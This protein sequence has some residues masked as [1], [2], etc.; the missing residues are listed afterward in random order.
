TILPPTV[1]SATCGRIGTAGGEV[2]CNANYGAEDIAVGE[3]P[4]DGGD[5]PE[6]LGEG[7]THVGQGSG[8]CRAV[9]SVRARSRQAQGEAA[10]RRGIPRILTVARTG[11]GGQGSSNDIAKGEHPRRSRAR[12]H[13]LSLAIQ[14]PRAGA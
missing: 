1:R 3:F 5:G 10:M 4:D 11:S 14:M 6:H 12:A 7:G 8:D 2:A 9:S 13:P